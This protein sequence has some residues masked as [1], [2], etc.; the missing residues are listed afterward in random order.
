[1]AIE[2]LLRPDFQIMVKKFKEGQI[3]VDRSRPASKLVVSRCADGL[4]YCK[5]LEPGNRKELAYLER[6]LKS[7]QD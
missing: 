5:A 1:M 7:L 6:D 2:A 3:V 4:Y